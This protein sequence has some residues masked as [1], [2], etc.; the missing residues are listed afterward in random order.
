[1]G[2]IYGYCRISTAKQSMDRQIRNIRSVYPDADIRQEVFTG[3]QKEG[4][5]QWQRLCQIVQ[6]G[7]TVVFDSVS[8]MSR[9][10]EEGFETYQN[11]Y[12]KG[13]NLIFLKEPQIDTDTYKQAMQN[14]V[15]TV[16]DSGDADTNKLMQGIINA[17]NEYVAALQKK[18]ILLAFEQAQKEVDDLRQRTREGIET[19]RLAEKQIGMQEGRKLTTKKSIAA[20][21]VI[22]KYSKDF[23]GT[24]NDLECMKLAE[25]SRNSY[26][27]YK[28]EL[29]TTQR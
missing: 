3:A 22:Q 15:N 29:K 2:K 19:A 13:V 25:I 26:Y 28:R 21:K 6:E 8:R 5:K 1:M 23:D 7:D 11:L 20:K 12:A 4:R 16:I 17:I 14:Q 18:Q 10:A 27:K 9:N 24:L